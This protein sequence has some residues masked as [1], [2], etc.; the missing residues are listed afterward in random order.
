M[1]SHNISLLCLCA[2]NMTSSIKKWNIDCKSLE[3]EISREKSIYLF[4]MCEMFSDLN[5]ITKIN[6]RNRV[7]YTNNYVDDEINE[8]I[9]TRN[10]LIGTPFIVLYAITIVFSLLGNTA[11]ILVMTRG[12]RSSRLNISIF[13]FNLAV[14]NLIMSFFC[15]P[16]TFLSTILKLKWILMPLTCPLK[17]FLQNM[18]INGSILSLTY[19]SIDSYRAV[20]HPLKH[21]S[22][23]TRSR[24]CFYFLLIW[25]ASCLIGNFFYFFFI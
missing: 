25:F 6:R 16:L 19:L 15:A 8:L 21:K 11:V 12:P 14:F 22:K 2:S 17:S 7:N 24:I 3:R 9:D 1:T 23:S 18:S 20:V 5:E 10:L 4:E 13:L